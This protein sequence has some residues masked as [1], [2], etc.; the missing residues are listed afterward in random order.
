MNYMSQKTILIVAEKE[1]INGRITRSDFIGVLMS[2][3]KD[4]FRKKRKLYR[5]EVYEALENSVNI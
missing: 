4:L 3:R 1:Y 2:V 5:K